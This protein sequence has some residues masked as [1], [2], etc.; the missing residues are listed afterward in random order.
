MY[1]LFKF[2]EI[3]GVA[4]NSI[5]E[6]SEILAIRSFEGLVSILFE[7]WALMLDD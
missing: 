2:S 4:M 1:N 6:S 5:F 7:R 3:F